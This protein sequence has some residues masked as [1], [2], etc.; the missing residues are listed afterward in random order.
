M[1]K[2][3]T[4]SYRFVSRAMPG[5]LV[6]KVMTEEPIRIPCV[7]G[8]N[9]CVLFF[10]VII[11]AMKICFVFRNLKIKEEGTQIS[12]SMFLRQSLRI[13]YT[14]VEYSGTKTYAFI[15]YINLRLLHN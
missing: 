4:I 10:C 3:L 5:S 11:K 2:L 7:Y 15:H 9:F 13:P 6:S 14:A 12:T 8:L 1:L